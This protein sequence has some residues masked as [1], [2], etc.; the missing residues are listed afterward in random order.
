MSD[1]YETLGVS[2][3]ATPEEIKKAYRKMARQ[4]HPDVNPGREAEERFKAVSHAYDVLSDPSKRAVYD[5][6]GDMGPGAGGGFGQGFTFTDIMD[7]FFGQGG[8]E[9]GPRSRQRRGQDALIRVQVELSEAVFGGEREIAVDTAVGCPTCHGEGA[10]PGTGTRRC[11]VC[12]GRGEVQTT[13][14]SFLGPVM[15]TRP[16]ATCQGYGSVIAHPCVQC[17][18]EGRVRSRRQ[19]NIRIPAGV[20]TGTRIQ[21]AGEGE[22]GAGNGPAGDLYVEIVVAPHPTFV[23]RGDDLHATVGLPMTA[24]ALGTT[25]TLET[26]D[27]PQELDVEPGT[28]S[29][30]TTTLRGLG[31][32]HLRGG[33]RGDLIVH[34]D[35]QT[36]RNLDEAQRRLLVELAA[37]RGE[38]RP[39][40]R[41]ASHG[42]GLFGRLKDALSGR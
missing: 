12:G 11:E 15:T 37:L 29:G 1:H 32:T 26:L 21:L 35:V 2:R 28:Q 25:V 17:S 18:G 23:R 24:A 10:Q 5:R 42:S 3:D 39:E 27:G 6:G 7:A 4:L 33:G 19:L 14:R 22:V 9:R 13:Q 31:V 40:G 20:D 8:A 38:E 16:C 36:P 41:L 34:V 30:E